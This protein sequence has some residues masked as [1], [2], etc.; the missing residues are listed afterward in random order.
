MHQVEQIEFAQEAHA[1]QARRVRVNRERAFDTVAFQKHLAARDFFEKFARK[2][3]SFEEQ[4]EVAFVES[5]IIEKR[6]EHVRARVVQKCGDFLGTRGSCLT[7]PGSPHLFPVNHVA[8]ARKSIFLA[9]SAAA[10]AG[11]TGRARK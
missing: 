3:S 10:C 7:D 11:L 1:D 8:L 9:S 2:L 6:Q 5:R 4:A